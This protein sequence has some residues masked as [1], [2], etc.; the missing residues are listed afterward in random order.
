MAMLYSHIVFTI[1]KPYVIISVFLFQGPQ[2]LRG[3]PGMVGPKGERVSH[4]PPTTVAK[5]KSK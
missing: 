5:M 2:G 3:Y 1:Y 4:V